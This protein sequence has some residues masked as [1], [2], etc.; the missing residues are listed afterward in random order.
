MKIQTQLTV[1]ERFH[2]PW[3]YEDRDQ[4]V[5]VL[6]V[7]DH[8]LMHGVLKKIVNAEND[9][10]VIAEAFD[11]EEAIKLAQETSPDIIIMDVNMPRKN[12]IEATKEIMS[13]MPSLRIIG[14]SLH[15]H[16]DVIKS[17]LTAGAS[18]YLTKDQAFKTLCSTIRREAKLM[19]SSGVQL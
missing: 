14:L 9:L 6:L 10:T 13:R 7:D 15:D 5:K 12:G 1:R 19:R 18:A 3:V 4:K 8:Q 17:M 11:G 16:E 2:N